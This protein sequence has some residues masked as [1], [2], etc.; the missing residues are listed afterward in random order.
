MKKIYKF[1]TL[2]FA[3]VLSSIITT[4]VVH[5][6]TLEMRYQDNIYYVHVNDDGSEYSSYQ[7]AMFYVDGKLAYCIEPGLAIYS[8]KYSTGDWNITSLNSD[9]RRKIEL[10]GYYGYEYPGHQGNVKYY[11]AAQELI[12]KVVKPLNATW[13]T[14]KRGGGQIISLEAEKNEILNLI[15][16]HYKKPSF[17]D[18][19]INSVIGNSF[20]LND[21]NNV[22]SE[23]EVYSNDN[24]DVSID[25]NTLNV[26]VNSTGNI[27]I[28]FIRKSYDND[29]NLIYYNSNSQK[30]AHTRF[31]EPMVANL[32]IKSVAGTVKINKL[33]KDTN[34]NKAQGEG[35]LKGAVY[36]IFNENDEYITSLT[37]DELGKAIS[38]NLPNLGRYYIKEKSASIGYLVDNT[39]YYFNMTK[40]NLNQ[41]INVYEKVISKSYDIRKVYASNKTGIMTPERN[42]EFGIY[43][44]NNKLILKKTTDKDGKIYFTLPYGRYTLRQLTTTPGYEKIK[45]YNFEIKDVGEKVNKIFSNAEITSKI[46]IIKVDENGNRVKKSGI[47]FKIKNIDTN[48]YVCQKITYPNEKTICEYETTSDGTLITP[49]PL[50][51]GNYQIEEINQKITGYLW[52]KTPLKFS[53]NE[54]STIVKNGDDSIIELRFKNTEVKGKI[55]INK[56]GEKFTIEKNKYSYTTKKLENVLFGVYDENKNLI[57]KIYTD[58]NGYAEITNLKLGVYYI[59]EL[60]TSKGYILDNKEYKIELT[61]KDQYTSIVTSNINLKNYL[62]KGTLEFTKTDLVNGEVIPN[63]IVEIYN[64]NDELIFTGKTDENGK[65]IIDDLKLG[66]YYI[67]EKEPATGYT[68][69]TEKVYFEIKKNKEIVKANMK[70]K[71]IT[72]ILEFTKT[73]VSTSEALPNTLIEIYNENDELIFSGRT[74]ENGKIIIPGLRYGK[75]Y[76]VEKEASEGYNLNPNK[77]WFEI[78]EDGKVVKSTMTDEKMVVEVPNTNKN[79]NL[80]LGMISLISL[81]LGCAIY[82]TIKSKK[83]KK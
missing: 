46:K 33:D 65:I 25:N 18:S 6:E 51:Y 32:K 82:G 50:N 81:G 8:T 15:N 37:T 74:N 47:K 75:Y 31:S 28:R 83:R 11:M 35:S 52:N 19:T 77:M 53:I 58:K 20:S 80:V 69:T 76:I 5:A 2:L 60:E 30:L 10:I 67:V 40:E 72:G 55:T 39:K 17:N 45:D 54:N 42:V 9:Q 1:I 13:S 68:I 71:P 56:V 79:D 23:Y 64:E 3:I 44:K 59:K 63:T 36:D 43:D 22:L 24:Q 41:N 49:Y 38:V 34:K 16:N 73:D 57:K 48:K 61:Y 26:K 27:E 21:S 12:W 29:I 4:N 7:L 70:D 78:L 14:E 62:E 66:K